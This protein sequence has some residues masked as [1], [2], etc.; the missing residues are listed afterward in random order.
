[1]RAGTEWRGLARAMTAA[2]VTA[3]LSAVCLFAVAA[4][5]GTPADAFSADQPLPEARPSFAPTDLPKSALQERQ[6]R[7][8]E[9]GERNGRRAPN[10]AG[11]RD[12]ATKTASAPSG[13]AAPAFTTASATSSATSSATQRAPAPAPMVLFGAGAAAPVVQAAP[14]RSTLRPQGLDLE[15][16]RSRELP[17]SQL[18]PTDHRSLQSP[19]IRLLQR[20]LPPPAYVFV[21]DNRN[22]VVAFLAVLGALCWGGIAAYRHLR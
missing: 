19:V 8:F 3:L 11:A 15:N 18:D 17:I 20:V 13:S 22:L 2:S 1:M 21:R 7:L 10:S 6:D 12:P 4:P 9:L 14:S 16:L 5:V